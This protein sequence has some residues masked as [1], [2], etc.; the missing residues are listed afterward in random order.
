[1]RQEI[2][3]NNTRIAGAFPDVR[4]DLVRSNA[5]ELGTMRIVI[6]STREDTARAFSTEFTKG[7]DSTGVIKAVLNV[8]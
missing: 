5:K 8:D 6:P 2:D 3:S 4:F 1:M 7:G